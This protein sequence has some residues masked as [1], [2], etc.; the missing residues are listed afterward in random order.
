ML[1]LEVDAGYDKIPV[2]QTA[3]D[4]LCSSVLKNDR[5]PFEFKLILLYTINVNHV[6]IRATL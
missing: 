1:P 3:C 6:N 2:M 4:I 5:N